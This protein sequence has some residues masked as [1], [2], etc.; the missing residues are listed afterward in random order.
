MLLISMLLLVVVG[1]V[2]LMELTKP[3]LDNFTPPESESPDGFWDA[4]A[5]WWELL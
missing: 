2:V 3:N 1:A 5:G 4:V